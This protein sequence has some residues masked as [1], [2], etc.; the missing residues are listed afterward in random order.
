MRRSTVLFLL[1]SAVSLCMVRPVFHM[2]T[3]QTPGW[4]GFLV[5]SVFPVFMALF[6]KLLSDQDQ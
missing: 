6:L 3:G 1:V 4:E 5:V 2:K